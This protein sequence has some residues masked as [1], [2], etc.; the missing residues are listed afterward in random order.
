MDL[1]RV[2]VG[3]LLFA[4]CFVF[5]GAISLALH[6]FV[7]FQ[8][9]VPQGIPWREPLALISAAL[10]LLPGLGL[11]LPST[12]K[13]SALTL[14]AFVA[15]WVIALWIPQVV[16]HPR[17]EGNWLGVGEDLTLVVGGWLIYGT[18]AGLTDA[19]VR[20]AR[21]LFGLAL[22]PIGLSHFFYLKGA[23]NFIPGWLPFHVPLTI[24][25]GAGHIAAGLAIACGLVPRLAVTLEASME[26]LIT[27]IVWVSAIA[28][29]PADHQ[30]WVNLLISSAETAAA[31]VVA[32]S[33]VKGVALTRPAA[34]EP[35]SG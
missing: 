28:V 2:G 16:A 32:A 33:Y 1:R 6:D 9:P 3:H 7:L 27:L 29:K 26:S 35:L 31:W 11:L 17:V 19:N 14:S 4:L 20:I 10:M 22:V 34:R 15:L 12:T 30:N 23:A 21:I 5:I 18:A 25:A 13:V 8:Q 24:L